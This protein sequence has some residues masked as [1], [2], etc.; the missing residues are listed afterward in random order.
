MKSIILCADDFG[1]NRETSLSI[2]ELLTKQRL[3][4]TSCMTNMPNWQE[5]A[6]QLKALSNS[7]DIGLHFNFN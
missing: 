1:Y 4:A 2:I 5:Q 3:S 7:V 6:T